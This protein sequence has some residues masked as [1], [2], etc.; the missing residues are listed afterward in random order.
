MKVKADPNPVWWLRTRG[1]HTINVWAGEPKRG[2]KNHAPFLI[3]LA[4]G[5][6]THHDGPHPSG[7][8]LWGRQQDC[9]SL[10]PEE[11]QQISYHQTAFSES[12]CL[13]FHFS[14]V[15]AEAMKEKISIGEFNVK[16]HDSS[17]FMF[18]S[19]LYLCVC[20]CSY[21][22]LCCWSDSIPC[23]YVFTGLHNAQIYASICSL[24]EIAFLVV[25]KL[26]WPCLSMIIVQCTVQQL[27]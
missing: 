6:V 2:V 17:S 24:T 26:V 5:T 10:P 22:T 27:F 7:R 11:H 12:I 4:T 14:I 25:K 20:Y 9:P 3:W 23:R 18:C 21:C 19:F 16:V 13:H 15:K 1:G 8:G